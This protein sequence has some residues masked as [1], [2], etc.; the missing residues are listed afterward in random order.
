MPGV[1]WCVVRADQHLERE[2][3]LAAARAA[4]QQRR[5]P[6]RQ[7][8]AGDVVESLDAAGDL[9]DGHH[10]PR[11]SVGFSCSRGKFI[12]MPRL[13]HRRAFRRELA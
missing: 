1:P 10:A 6:Q 5:P 3:R 2:D 9:F 7:S 8:A 12:A 4:H 13:C 11:G